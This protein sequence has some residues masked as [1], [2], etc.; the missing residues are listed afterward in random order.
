MAAQNGHQEITQMLL[1]AG[2]D[3][4]NMDVEVIV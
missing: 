2:A 1:D 3:A 4:N